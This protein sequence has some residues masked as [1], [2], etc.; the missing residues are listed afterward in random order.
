MLRRC[1]CRGEVV[2]VFKYW[3]GCRE[4]PAY[5]GMTDVL[6]SSSFLRRLEPPTTT[7]IPA[8]AGTS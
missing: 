8:Q 1:F 6:T 4:V 2:V 3:W 5:A 7:V